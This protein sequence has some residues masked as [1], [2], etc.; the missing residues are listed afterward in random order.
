MRYIL[1]NKDKDFFCFYKKFLYRKMAEP[2]RISNGFLPRSQA[3]TEGHV[4]HVYI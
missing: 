3:R 4:I 2:F 1:T